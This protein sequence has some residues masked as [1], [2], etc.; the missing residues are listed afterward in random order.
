MPLDF[1]AIVIGSGFGGAV[2]ACRLA[3]SGARVLVLE[4][5]RR[6]TTTTFPRQP[7]DPWLWDDRRPQERSG[8]FDFRAFSDMTIVQG[9]GV[10]GGSLH[11]ANV[12]IDAKPDTFAS[13]WPPEITMQVLRPHFDRVK[14]MLGSSP[15]PREQESAR[16][17][18]MREAADKAGYSFRFE[19]LDLAISFDPDWRYTLPDPH[20]TPHSKQHVNPHGVEQGTC[21]HLG[22]CDIGC[23]VN[24]RNTLDLNYIAVAEQQHADVRPFHLVRRVAPVTGGYAVHF[25][26]IQPGAL[27]PGSVTAGLVVVSAGSLGSTEILLRSKAN[28]DL[29]NLS[30]RLGHGWSSNGDFLTPALHFF[31]PEPVRPTRGPTITAAINLLDGE[32]LGQGIFIE[33]GGFPDLLRS[34]L[35]DLTQQPQANRLVQLIVA[36]LRPVLAGGNA[37]DP[38]MPWFAQARDAAD[39]TLSL[40]DDHVSLE[41]DSSQSEA[42]INAVA[43]MHRR[44]AFLTGGMPLTPLT[45]TLDRHLVTPHPLGGCRIGV[46]A[47]D[48]V[49]DWK[50]EAF[51]HPRLYVAD[52]AV[53]P[54]AIGL[55]PSKTIAALAEHIVSHIG[56]P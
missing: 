10:G 56:T 51:G 24:A 13:G 9:A 26:R 53:L 5:G 4:R 40:I 43:A 37:L 8:W 7:D 2:T 28:G 22:H 46:S 55:N 50:G 19:K 44:L 38:V 6:W 41:W 36:S 21:V 47:A 23:D 29:P 35:E 15:V 27:V 30:N 45:W 3:Q 39:G 49:I 48:G 20:G 34:Y 42:T 31:R 12:S 17:R 14:G 52:G 32:Y 16:T 18:L 1:D 33:D 25:D 11:Y 54:K